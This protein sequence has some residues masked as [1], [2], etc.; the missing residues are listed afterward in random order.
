MYAEKHTGI[1]PT[2]A[3]KALPIIP[4]PKS[5]VAICL[6]GWLASCEQI[7]NPPLDTIDPITVVDGLVSDSASSR[8]ILTRTAPYNA[9]GPNPRI[10]SAQVIVYPAGQAAVFF[11]ETS[12]GLYTPPTAFRGR[13]GAAYELAI[14]LPDGQELFGRSRMP[15]I[16][17][18]DSLT[19]RYRSRD[20]VFEAGYY[21]TFHM[22]DLPGQRNY[23]LFN[24][25]V[26]GRLRNNR[27]L[28]LGNDQDIDGQYV[29]I[30]L[31]YPLNRGDTVLFQAYSLSK[32]A[33][34]YYEGVRALTA[35]G[36][37]TQTVPENPV[38]TISGDAIG[39]FRASAMRS[40]SIIIR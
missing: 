17:P 34:N 14:R 5:L 28:I 29:S 33:Y 26:N 9:P 38:S 30:Q 31:A 8:V 24:L 37:P 21:V 18:I 20:P 15:P 11:T 25:F 2:A 36:S 23:Y 40:R 32:E 6:L 1:S 10:T 27:E 3:M 35:V 13:P 7:V 4:W 16:A 39:V 12:P 22:R 19:Y